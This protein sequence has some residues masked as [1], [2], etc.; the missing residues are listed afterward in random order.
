MRTECNQSSIFD[1]LGSNSEEGIDLNHVANCEECATQYQ[2]H[3]ELSSAVK[4]GPKATPSIF[5]DRDLK[6]RLQEE[7][8]AMRR[9]R[10]RS[11]LLRGYWLGTAVISYAIVQS[12]NWAFPTVGQ[13][14]LIS[15]IALVVLATIIPFV[16]CLG[17]KLKRPLTAKE[18]LEIDHASDAF[19]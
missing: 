1:E 16:L 13:S 15:A 9:S 17:L 10:V 4:G 6:A 11:A 18:A 5:F 12:T 19:S 14:V 8:I 2:V 3:E 7:Q